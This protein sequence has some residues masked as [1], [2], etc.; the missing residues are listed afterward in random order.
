MSSEE[1]RQSTGERV[2]PRNIAFATHHVALL[3]I[4]IFSQ[5]FTEA[6]YLNYGGL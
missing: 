4:K 5:K 1:D 3:K 6:V 2:P